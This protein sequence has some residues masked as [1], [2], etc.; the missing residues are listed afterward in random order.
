M[1]RVGPRLAV[2][3]FLFSAAAAPAQEQGLVLDLRSETRDL[4]STTRDLV[5]A[6]RDLVA[7][8]A[9]LGGGVKKLE[10]GIESLAMKET[11]TEIRIELSGD[12]LF[13]FDKS[14]IRAEAEPVLSGV[15]DVLKKHPKAAVMIAG[16]TDAKGA[17]NYNLELSRRRAASVKSWLL[18]HGGVRGE[19]L[20]TR[21]F[22]KAKPVA[23][24]TRPDG[25]DDPEGR[26]RNRR[27]EIVMRK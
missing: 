26:Q 7:T 4:V 3:C 13:H 21:G 25:S 14:D 15:A 27:V 24:N 11:D 9:D 1:C 8:V 20:G 17:D 6:T 5:A 10:G 2:L 18:K 23:P 19:R 16:Y 22:G 12:V